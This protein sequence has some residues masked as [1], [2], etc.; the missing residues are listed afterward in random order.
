MDMETLMTTIAIVKTIPDTAV[1]MSEAAAA[2]A[3][4]AADTVESATITETKNYLEI[5]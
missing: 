2:R 4:A 3:E 5:V 1:S